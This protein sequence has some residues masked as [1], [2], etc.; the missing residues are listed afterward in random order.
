[1][2]RFYEKTLLSIDL[3]IKIGIKAGLVT[4]S[5]IL[6]C[7]NIIFSRFIY[8]TNRWS[9]K[10]KGLDVQLLQEIPKFS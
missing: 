4:F 2:N 8:K 10:T 6:D 7:T 5:Q 1:M 3:F 9:T